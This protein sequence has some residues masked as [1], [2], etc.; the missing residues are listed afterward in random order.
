MEV[1]KICSLGAGIM[2]SQIAQL[3][4]TSGYEVSMLDIED[5]FVQAG[6]N[7][8][9]KTLQKFFV[10]K[11]KMTQA[12]A[13]A[14]M[15]KITG[16]TDMKKA[17]Q[18]AQLVIE[19]IPELLDLKQQTFKAL[20]ETCSPDTI[21]A[22]NTSSFMVSQIGSLAKR[23]DKLIGL[24]YFNPIARMKLVEII[25]AVK[26]S[27]DTFNTVKEV[28]LKMGREPITVLDSPAFVANRM[29]HVMHCEAVKMLQEG[30]ATAED[31]DKA[32]T[33]GLGHSA[34]PF[35]S[36]DFTNAMGIAVELGDYLGEMLGER[37]RVAPLVRKKALAGET[38][39]AAG[40]GYFEY[41]PKA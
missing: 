14:V 11:E 21:L 3:A 13:D 32:C 7:S 17:V 15:G 38:G 30:I 8:I 33:M 40:K 26:T 31:I 34:G 39:M 16:T 9:K 5:R 27:D 10:E 4:A 29:L 36:V 22:S 1:K 20:D 41:P 2:G 37:Y 19:S 25:R 35:L 12:E 23:Q 18:G 6:L 28:S 24:H